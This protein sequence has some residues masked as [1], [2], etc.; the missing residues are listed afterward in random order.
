[1]DMYLTA[2]GQRL[3]IPL[4]PDRL[5]VKMG[6]I[7]IA[8]QTIK[9]SEHKIPRGRSL[10]GYSWNGLFPGIGMAEASF[11]HDWQQPTRICSTLQKW[12]EDKK[13]IRFM[14]TETAINDD[15]FIENFVFDHFGVDNISYTITLS[16]YKKLVISTAPPQPEVI[17]PQEVPPLHLLALR[18]QRQKTKRPQQRQIRRQQS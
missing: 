17:I 15:V 8:F 3:R 10:T 9:G 13:I 7:S 18:I 11:V 2:D 5:T 1:M 6:A 4:L 14:V 12:M 16:Q